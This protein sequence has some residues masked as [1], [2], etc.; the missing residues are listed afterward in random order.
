MSDW[1]HAVSC[2]VIFPG[3]VCIILGGAQGFLVGKTM[4]WLIM[5]RQDLNQA[6]ERTAASIYLSDD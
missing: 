3:V 4:E 2:I 6:L 1:W 5:H